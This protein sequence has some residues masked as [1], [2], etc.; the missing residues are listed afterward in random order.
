M[1]IK[2]SIGSAKLSIFNWMSVEE[3]K[4]CYAEKVVLFCTLFK[5]HNYVFD[6][7]VKEEL[8]DTSLVLSDRLVRGVQLYPSTHM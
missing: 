5:Y 4:S 2:D 3:M 6:F 7:Y 1:I 8:M